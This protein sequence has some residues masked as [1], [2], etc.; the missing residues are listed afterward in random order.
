M[1][2]QPNESILES[3]KHTKKY[4]WKRK[5]NETHMGTEDTSITRHSVSTGTLIKHSKTITDKCIED[6]PKHHLQPH[7][8][9]K[10][11]DTL[12]FLS[13]LEWMLCLDSVKRITPVEGLGHRFITMKHLPKDPAVDCYVESSRMSMKVCPPLS[14]E[15]EIEN[16]V[17]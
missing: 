6:L 15:N 16:F 7:T 11:E 12:A 5:G 10:V 2:G 3:G 8:E 9:S 13:L 1:L 17:T 4:F 14:P